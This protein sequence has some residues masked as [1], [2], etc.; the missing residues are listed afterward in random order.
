MNHAAITAILSRRLDARD[1]S[2]HIIEEWEDELAAT[3]GARVVSWGS[4]WRWRF[5]RLWARTGLPFPGERRGCKLAFFLEPSQSLSRF[6]RPDVVPWFI[7]FWG[8]RGFEDLA[9]FHAA[10]PFWIV[11]DADAVRAVRARFPARRVEHGPVFL[12][13][14]HR[15]MTPAAKSVD[16]VQAG[17]QDPV[18]HAG[19]LE[20]VAREPA[21]DYVFRQPR[22]ARWTYVST[23]RGELG[24]L[25]T[26][27]AYWDLLRSARVALVSAPGLDP[28]GKQT[29]GFHPITPRF[30]E[31]A[32]AGCHLVVRVADN[33]DA[34][35]FGV[36]AWARVVD[37]AP[38]SAAAV[39]AA[40]AAGAPPRVPDV[41]RRPPSAFT[42]P[43]APT[44]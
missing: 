8:G 43:N 40:L 12:P 42:H 19:A 2:R 39:L 24:P 20:S 44:T 22:G 29:G 11:A 41:V 3:W 33:L 36:R 25:D 10:A 28:A 18:L 21:L 13:A 37:D 35:H 27:P 4:P 15:A 5:G 23:R 16:I 14:R 38:G 17:R 32:A 26:R 31:A 6:T 30:L 34:A 9:R 7:D 1:L